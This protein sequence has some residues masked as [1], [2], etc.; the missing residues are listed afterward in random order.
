MWNHD[1][2]QGSDAYMHTQV[3]KSRKSLQKHQISLHDGQR[4]GKCQIY[5]EIEE[6]KDKGEPSYTAKTTR[7]VREWQGQVGRRPRAGFHLT[8]VRSANCKERVAQ[9]VCHDD[10]FLGII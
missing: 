10:R 2:N 8:S 4:N 7:K 6:Y 5:K 1:I 9:K 3:L